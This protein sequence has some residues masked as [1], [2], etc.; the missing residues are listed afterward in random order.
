MAEY[1]CCIETTI[2]TR[3]ILVMQMQPMYFGKV[4][5]LIHPHHKFY[6]MVF[7]HTVLT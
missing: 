2:L 3:E 5:H 7:L 1:D 6:Q 4:Y